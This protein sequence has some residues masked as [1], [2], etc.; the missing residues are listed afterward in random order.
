MRIEILYNIKEVNKNEH[1]KDNCWCQPIET[2]I[3]VVHRNYE[4]IN[5]K[6]IK[7]VKKLNI[8]YK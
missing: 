4:W 7:V 1:T 6:W 8:D 5:N 3:Y 2:P